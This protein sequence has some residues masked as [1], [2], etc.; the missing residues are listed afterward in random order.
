LAGTG[1]TGIG[2]DFDNSGT[3]DVQSGKLQFTGAVTQHVGSQLTG[4]SWHVRNNATLDLLQAPS[5]TTSFGNIIL[6]GPGSTFTKIDS[7]AD[8]RGSFAILSERNFAVTDF[9]TNSGTVVIG[10]G[11]TFTVPN[12]FIQQA[13]GTLLGGGTL[14]A[15]LRNSGTVSPGSSPGVLSING[16]YFQQA[17]GALE[18]EIGGVLKGPEY[19][20][21]SISGVASLAGMLDVSLIDLGGSP[22]SPQL[23]QSFEILTADAGINGAFDSINL[24]ELDPGLLWELDYLELG[25]LILGVTET[26]EVTFGGLIESLVQLNLPNGLNNSLGNKLDHVV[27]ALEA[28]NADRRQNAIHNLHAFINQVEAQLGKKIPAAAGTAL[29]EDALKLIDT[30]QNRSPTAPLVVRRHGKSANFTQEAVPEPRTL[31]LWLSALIWSFRRRNAVRECRLG[32]TGD[33]E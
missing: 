30:M 15:S 7:L 11:S 3:V 23:D 6:E 9:F 18:I 2:V 27:R 29:I 21:L 26:E 28:P 5:I 33:S 4:G 19:D 31:V 32:Q 20:S 8:N 17:F 25:K 14:A 12:G 16:D 22:F 24:P 1:S 13:S 10:T